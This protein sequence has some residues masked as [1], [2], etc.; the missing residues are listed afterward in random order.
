MTDKKY[1]MVIGLEVHVELKT[2]S[3][4]FCSCSTAFGAEPNT[5]C[6]PV[7]MGMPGTLPVLNEKVVEYAIKAGLAT[8]CEIA[9]YSKQDRKNYFYPDLPKAYQISQF[10][11]PLCTEGRLSVEC[12]GEQKNIRIERIHIEE[13]A[14]KLLH[15]DDGTT[16]CDYNRCG[17]P[18]IEIVTY[19]DMTSAAQVDKFLRKLQAILVYAGVSDCKMQEGSM[20]CDV[21]I[22]VKEAS[23]TK[24]GTRAEIK[25]LNS[26]NAIQK[27]I[28]YEFKRQTEDIENGESIVQ[29]TRRFDPVSNM[30]YS[31]RS[32]E[33]SDDY[34]YFPDPDLAPIISAESYIN[35]IKESIPEL[36]DER[37]KRYMQ[38][39]KLTSAEAE[40]IVTQKNIA[41]YYEACATIC[42]SPKNLCNLILGEIFNIRGNSE[43]DIP[44]SKEHLAKLVDMQTKGEIN[45]TTLKKI[46]RNIWQED[47]DP[48]VYAEEMHLFQIK[49]E[50]LLEG[51]AAEAIKMSE[52]AVNDIKNGKT[53]AKQAIVGKAMGLSSGLADAVKLGE[54]IDKLLGL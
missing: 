51:F 13:D 48:Y 10:D 4:I 21:N 3:K 27:A 36:P 29:E 23:A 52:K 45:N 37:K 8:N 46:V 40:L 12:G 53:T 32:K 35:K 39:Y 43:E 5:H 47:K 2:Q 28:E 54:L 15:N 17:V 9:P 30:T 20:R 38:E 19:P 42:S 1:D 16:F 7:C 33:N 24:L 49:D 50:N 22:S 6:C 41:D 11:L 44:I 18:L 14:G 31:M 25:N 34:R 26:F